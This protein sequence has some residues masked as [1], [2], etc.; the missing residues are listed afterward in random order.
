MQKQW[1]H[2][3]N[4]NLNRKKMKK[5]KLFTPVIFPNG[6]QTLINIK[7]IKKVESLIPEPKTILEFLSDQRIMMDAGH[8][9]NTMKIL[10]DK[11]TYEGC[12]TEIKH[13][14]GKDYKNKET[15]DILLEELPLIQIIKK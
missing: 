15:I 11:E 13:K 1:Q 7:N 5:A 2:N 4:S 8:Q 14:A 9:F 10:V 12:I 6:K 3:G